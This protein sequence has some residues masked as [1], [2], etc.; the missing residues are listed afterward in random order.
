MGL[1]VGLASMDS[2]G[3]AWQ[4]GSS[5]CIGDSLEMP[6]VDLHGWELKDAG[7][8]GEKIKKI[9]MIVGVRIIVDVTLITVGGP[10]PCSCL[11]SSLVEPILRH[12]NVVV[13]RHT[14]QYLQCFTVLY[15]NWCI[16]IMCA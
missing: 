13:G 7:V 6:S 11:S 16:H 3:F 4:S 1:G 2:E 14:S 8:G 10:A 15:N 5:I 9:S 12:T